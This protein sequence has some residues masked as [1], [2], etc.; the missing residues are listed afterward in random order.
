M[1]ALNLN[2]IIL[3]HKKTIFVIQGSKAILQIGHS[4][5]VKSLYT[6]KRFINHFLPKIIVKS[7]MLRSFGPITFE[8]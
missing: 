7:C 4:N 8:K 2:E 5:N 3:L 6:F 1:E